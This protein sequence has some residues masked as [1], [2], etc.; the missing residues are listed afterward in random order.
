MMK[1]AAKANDLI[2][3]VDTHV[4][5]VAGVP[6]PLPSLFNGKI[7]GGLS[8]DVAIENLP[9]ATEGSTAINTAPHIPVG[10]LFAK[11]PTNMGSVSAGSGTV[12]INNKA[13]GR[14]GDPAMTCNDPAD[15]P[16]GTIVATSTI[17]IGG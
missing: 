4:V 10:G 16:A 5:I 2:I 11:P 8:T 17:L 9:A 3:A 13:A 15:L 1:P 12:L 6:T 7:V 14:A